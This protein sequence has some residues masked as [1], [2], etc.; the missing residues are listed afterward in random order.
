MA[1]NKN[2]FAPPDTLFDVYWGANFPSVN[3]EP[4]KVANN[5][6]YQGAM[7]AVNNDR[8]RRFPNLGYYVRLWAESADIIKVDYGDWSYFYFLVPKGYG[9]DKP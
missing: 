7:R 3:V 8:R 5:V 4:I 6:T 9:G 1:D 2:P